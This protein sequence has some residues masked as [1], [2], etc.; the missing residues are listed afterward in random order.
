MP[1]PSSGNPI[2]L[3][4]IQT[5]FGGS[6]PI[7]MDEYYRNASYTTSNNTN[8][9]TSG[10]ISLSNFY[11][12]RRAVFGCTDP[13]ATNYNPNA[14]DSDG[15]CSYPPPPVIRGCTD[16]R[17]TNYNRNATQDDG[18]CTYPCVEQTAIST[19]GSGFF[20]YLWYNNGEKIPA[21]NGD[22]KFIT[23]TNATY[24]NASGQQIT[25]AGGVVTRYSDIGNFIV[26]HYVSYFQ[27]YPEGIGFDGWFYEFLNFPGYTSFNVLTTALNTAYNGSGGEK[28]I[29]QSKGGLKGNYNDC[30]VKKV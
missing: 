15:S 26:N 20:G 24:T 8:V 19:Y 12:S 16:P 1:L 23:S 22:N 17:A 28:D 11:G 2:S 25:T 5:E 10:A 29:R 14:T 4:Q 27:R 18:S 13:S 9:P 30:G 6:N 7:E 3:G 21:N